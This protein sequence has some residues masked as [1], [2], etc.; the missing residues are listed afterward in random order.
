MNK[1][2]LLFTSIATVFAVGVA[3]VTLSGL[4]QIQKSNEIKATGDSVEHTITLTVAD[5]EDGSTIDEGYLT[6]MLYQENATRSG[7]YFGYI[8]YAYSDGAITYGTDG[9]I[10][11]ATYAYYDSVF[12]YMILEFSNVKS[13]TSVTLNGEFYYNLYDGQLKSPVTSIE[14]TSS[15]F[16]DD[17]LYIYVED[18]YKAALTSVV[19]VYDCAA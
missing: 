6:Y 9:N 18:L 16:S 2:A 12:F 14:Y 5:L 3:T 19:I 4:N 8:G 13:Y 7:D 15:D 11:S 17:Q 1:K 10:F